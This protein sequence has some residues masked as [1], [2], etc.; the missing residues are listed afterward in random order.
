MV[1]NVSSNSHKDKNTQITVVS[2]ARRLSVFHSFTNNTETCISTTNM[3]SK[4]A[5]PM[6]GPLAQHVYNLIVPWRVE[7]A[8]SVFGVE[9][10]AGD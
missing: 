4:T 10:L 2:K 7:E 3:T 9:I 6:M 8:H 5:H 1:L